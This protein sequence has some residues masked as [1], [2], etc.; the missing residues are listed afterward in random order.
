[1]NKILKIPL[2]DLKNLLNVWYAS[3][4]VH[5]INRFRAVILDP[6][7]LQPILSFISDISLL[8][9]FQTAHDLFQKFLNIIKE[10]FHKHAALKK[11]SRKQQKLREK[12]WIT[13]GIL[14]SINRKN[15]LYQQSLKGD[16]YSKQ[17]YKVY[18]NKLTH[19]KELSKKLYYNE[20]ITKSKHN[21]ALIWKSIN[22]ITQR[23]KN[24]D[25]FINKIIDKSNHLV[26]DSKQICETLNN[27]FSD[28]GPTVEWHKTFAHHLILAS[29][30]TYP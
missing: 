20:L 16:N 2:S 13:R 24:Y 27:H 30:Q 10:S 5:K 12:P 18:R 6:F 25:L 26:Y 22:N 11:A 4:S 17:T 28:I 14:K 21:S 9:S 7:S 3:L 15:K 29:L 23:T 1:M 19:I 8:I